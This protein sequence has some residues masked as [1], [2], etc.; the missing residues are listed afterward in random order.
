MHIPDG[1]LDTKT[2]VTCW[3]GAAGAIGYSSAWIRKHFDQSRIVLMAV[4]AALIFALQMLN[5]PVAGGTSGH[6][7]GGVLAGIILGPWP[8]AMVMTAVLLIQA[9]FF[10]DGGITTLGASVLNMGVI[11]PFLGWW[12]YRMFTSASTSRMARTAGSFAAAWAGVVASSLAVGI[13][14]WTSGNAE[15]F[16][17]MGAMGFWH[18]I[19]GIGEGVITAG[20]VLYLYSVRPELVEGRHEEGTSPM[21][22]VVVVLG[23]LALAAA[24]LSF[25]A[26][27]SPDGLEFVYFDS[28]IGAAFEEVSLVKSPFS[29]YLVPGISNDS[30][31]GI[32]AGVIGVAITGVLLWALAVSLKRR[33]S[34]K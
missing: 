32:A 1:M 11:A 23:I 29:D 33:R 8:A 13:Q 30:L 26:S 27:G 10:G 15:F 18:A 31:A 21:S 3:A 20:V 17:V 6:F 34:A 22:S 19:I 2:W 24:G 14:L 5:F 25:L 4:L 16:S 28:G 9:V 7:G 12:I